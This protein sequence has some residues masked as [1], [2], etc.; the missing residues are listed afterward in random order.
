MAGDGSADTWAGLAPL[1]LGRHRSD[2]LGL[3]E[4]PHLVRTLR[5]IGPEALEKD[6]GNDVVAA[7]EVVSAAG[8]I[9]KMMVLIDDRQIG[10]EDFLAQLVE[11]R[12]VRVRMLDNEWLRSS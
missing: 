1:C 2:E 10:I 7:A 6:S 4:W 3:A 8:P 9:P 5:A 12:E 11:P